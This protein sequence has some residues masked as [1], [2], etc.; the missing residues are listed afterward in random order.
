M[1]RGAKFE[2]MYRPVWCDRN[3]LLRFQRGEGASSVNK[4]QFNGCDMAVG[5]NTKLAI[6]SEIFGTHIHVTLSIL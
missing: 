6:S 1:C 2:H 4:Y 3:Q 5:C